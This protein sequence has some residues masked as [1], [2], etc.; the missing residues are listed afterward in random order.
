MKDNEKS[1]EEVIK[2]LQDYEVKP[3]EQLWK[4]INKK[5]HKYYLPRKAYGVIIAVVVG[6]SIVAGAV[7]IFSDGKTDSPN[8]VLTKEKAVLTKQNAVV[9]Q[10]NVVKTQPKVQTKEPVSI[11]LPQNDT[12]KVE[13]PVAEITDVPVDVQSLNIVKPNAINSS[14]NADIKPLKAVADDT[15]AQIRTTLRK[16]TAAIPKLY[17]PNAF[18]PYGNSNNIFKP[19]HKDLLSYEMTIYNSQGQILFR[20]KYIDS[21]WDGRSSGKMCKGGA[22][23]YIIS[24]KTA[25]GIQS[26]QSGSFMLVE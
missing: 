21:G 16:D 17:I 11:S 23:I 22:Y 26:Q 6:V 8:N 1:Y 2:D 9:L 5:I 14:V 13:M 25:D 15:I 4:N 20:T 18:T 7:A 12:S 19:A 10:N 24:F 3:D